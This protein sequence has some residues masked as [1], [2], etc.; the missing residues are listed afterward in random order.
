MTTT[1]RVAREAV[2]WAGGALGGL[3][4]LLLLAGWLFNVTPLVFGSGSMSPAYDTGALGIARQVPA[5]ELAVGDVVSVRDGDGDRVTHRVVSIASAADGA[6]V[7]RLQ[8]DANDVPDAEAYRVDEVDRVVAGVPL[9]GYVLNAAASPFGLAAGALLAGTA[10]FLGFTP[11]GGGG[12]RAATRRARL[13][14]PVGVGAVLLGGTV[15]M[16]GTAPWAFTSAY[17]TDTA[18]ATVAATTPAPVTHAQPNCASLEG[19]GQN[20]QQATLT[21]TSVGTQYEYYW[22]L[23]KGTSP[24]GSLYTT[25]TNGN[26]S[27][28]PIAP[29]AAGSTVTL[30]FGEV[31]QS[32]GG[33]NDNFYV[34]IWTRLASNHTN[35]GSPTTTLLHSGPRPNGPNWWMYCGSQ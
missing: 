19:Q 25:T 17:W 32:G 11:G 27:A 28:N 24:G 30:T 8:G 15:G 35:V 22:E 5:G 33:G 14:L 31:I 7:L 1:K 26:G 10:L 34:K 29:S 2:L 23:W 3:C 16:T 18:K 20:K 12:R 9:A 4:L 13:V 6:T 21:W